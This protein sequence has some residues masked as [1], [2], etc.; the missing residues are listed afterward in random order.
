[1]DTLTSIRVFCMVA[2]LKS[3]AAAAHRLGMSP[4]MASKHVMHLE[5]RLGTRL[6]N[7]TSRHL[8]LT[9]TG[10]LYFQQSSP[11]LD[12]LAD[13]EAAITKATVIPSGTL[14]ITAPVWFANPSFISLLADYRARY[15]DV[16]LDVDLSGR[17]VNMVEEGVDLALRVTRVPDE[18]LIARPISTVEFFLVGAPAY[19]RASGRPKR[20]RDLVNHAMLL[21]SLMP[22]T[23]E[24]SFAGPHGPEPVK[25]S[26]VLQSSN[27]SLLHLAALQG[28]GLAF[29]PKWLIAHDLQAGRLERLLPNY[30]LF[31]GQL[32]G[33]YPSRKYLSSKVRTFLDFIAA[34]ERLK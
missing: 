4:A 6:L 21:Y 19:L 8:S 29:L 12:G 31:E 24:M 32:L 10:A 3:F 27:E 23:T 28:M 26:P 16:R 13:A 18:T 34:D 33:V 25:L 2:E 14:K 20:V 22:S 17:I 30:R 11:L 7:R 9:E 5:R 15:P 1:M